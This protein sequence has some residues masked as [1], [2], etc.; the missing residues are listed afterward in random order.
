MRVNVERPIKKGPTGLNLCILALAFA[1]CTDRLLAQQPEL[2]VEEVQFWGPPPQPAHRVI[3]QPQWL[4]PKQAKRRAVHELVHPP[5]ATIQGAVLEPGWRQ[6]YAYG[7]FGAKP[8]R[9]PVRHFG[10]RQS[11]TQWTWK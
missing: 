10:Y 3:E 5:V 1:C 8:Y 11:Y 9:H 7:F 6:P 4:S 2:P